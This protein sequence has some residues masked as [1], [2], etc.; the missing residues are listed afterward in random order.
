MASVQHNDAEL[1]ARRLR[2]ALAA[3]G[4]AAAMAAYFDPAEGFVGMSFTCLGSNPRDEVTADDLLVVSLLDIV[5]RPTAVRMLLGDH[6]DKISALLQPISADIDLWDATDA[7][8]ATVDPLWDALLDMPGI[9]IATAAKLL[10]RKRP[11]LCP[12]TDRVLIRAS[13]VPGRTWN[14][15]RLLLQDPDAR[16]ELEA[17]RPP[18]AAGA[19]LLQLLDVAVWICHGRS[20]AAQRARA[21]G[22]NRRA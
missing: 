15:I 21:A 12:V 19:S 8:L 7:D 14:A 6:A 2:D 16:A 11:R 1:G 3:P 22:R 10:A 17:L 20:H 4:L 18:L 9:G 5:W 13:G